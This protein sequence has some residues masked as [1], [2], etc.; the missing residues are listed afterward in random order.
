MAVFKILF[1]DID[2]QAV[3]F[4]L[5]GILGTLAVD[6]T[7]YLTGSTLAA[8]AGVFA[9]QA[10]M[11]TVAAYLA[12]HLTRQQAIRSQDERANSFLTEAGTT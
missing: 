1:I 9:A 2:A 12:M 3:A 10:V 4:G 11:F 7:R 5:G 6:V 8:Y